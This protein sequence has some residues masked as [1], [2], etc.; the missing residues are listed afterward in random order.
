LFLAD[1]IA[2]GD[3]HNRLHAALMT[4]FCLSLL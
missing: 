1:L 2:Q 3:T 4:V